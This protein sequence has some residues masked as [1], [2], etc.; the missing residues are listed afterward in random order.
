MGPDGPVHHYTYAG[1]S[2]LFVLAAAFLI[3]GALG[4]RN[5]K[6]VR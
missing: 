5:V 2:T 1:Y 4:L 3:L 6:R